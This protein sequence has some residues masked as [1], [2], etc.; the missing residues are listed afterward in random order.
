V[1]AARKRKITDGEASFGL[2][3]V[4]WKKKEV[5]YRGLDGCGGLSPEEVLAEGDTA[6]EGANVDYLIM[7]KDNDQLAVHD[8]G[9]FEEAVFDDEEEDDRETA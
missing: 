3:V 2:I 7:W 5:D 8:R 4:D 9:G 1:S 6:P